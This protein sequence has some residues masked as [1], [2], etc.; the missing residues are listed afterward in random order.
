MLLRRTAIIRLT[1]LAADAPQV[2]GLSRAGFRNLSPDVNRQYLAD[3]GHP[4]HRQLG[5]TVQLQRSLAEEEVD[6]IVVPVIAAAAFLHQGR[7]HKV[8]LCR[9]RNQRACFGSFRC[10]RLLRMSQEF[11]FIGFWVILDPRTFNLLTRFDENILINGRCLCFIAQLCH[12]TG[13][14]KSK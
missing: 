12:F 10:I 3:A 8:R 5:V 7:A 2:C 13:T 1:C 14:F 6:L 11:L 4:G 9:G